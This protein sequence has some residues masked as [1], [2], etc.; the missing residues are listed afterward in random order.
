MA[1]LDP[2]VV[3]DQLDVLIAAYVDMQVRAE[4]DDLSDLPKYEMSELSSRLYAGVLRLAPRSSPYVEQAKDATPTIHIRIPELVGIVRA[5][6]AD[7]SAGWLTTVEEL[8]HADTFSDFLGQASELSDKGYKDAAA[9]LTGGV[10]EAHLRALCVKYGVATDLPNGGPKKANLLNA[11]LVKASAYNSIQ[12]K[13]I[14]S[15][16]A[17]RNAAAHGE[18]TKYD[19]IGVSNMISAV[20]SFIALNP[21]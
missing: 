14:E 16:I 13:A 15:W 9:V 18:F 3:I 5:M 20:Q 10:L 12:S 1:Q 6:K 17:I 21:A 11:D 2:S 8:L 7:I 4:H 19:A